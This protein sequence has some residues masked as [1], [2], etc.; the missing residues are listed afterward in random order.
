MVLNKSSTYDPVP[1]ADDVFQTC[2]NG[3]LEKIYL[4]RGKG[5][6]MTGAGAISFQVTGQ[7]YFKLASSTGCD[8]PQVAG[9]TCSAQIDFFPVGATGNFEGQISAYD[10]GS[11]M[12]ASMSL[13]A[14]SVACP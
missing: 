6:A 13:R 9:A 4:H 12:T 2:P 3:A 11:G 14:K 1:L 8:Q 7:P 10:S 5:A